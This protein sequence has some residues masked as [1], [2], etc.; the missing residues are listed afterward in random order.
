MSKEVTVQGIGP[1]IANALQ[2]VFI[3][4]ERGKR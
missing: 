1:K 2:K 3:L 4:F